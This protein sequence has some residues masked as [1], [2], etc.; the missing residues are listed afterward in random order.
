[1]IEGARITNARDHA[2][3]YEAGSGIT[4][5]DIVSTG[6]GS[7]RGFYSSKGSNPPGVTFINDSFK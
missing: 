3:R 4:L 5:K 7:G 2:V 6:T 1:V